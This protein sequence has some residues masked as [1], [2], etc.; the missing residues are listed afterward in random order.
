MLKNLYVATNAPRSGKSLISLGI[1]EILSRRVER[2]GFFRPVI[3]QTQAPD[4]DIEL[5]RQRYQL[6]VPYE[7]LY[8]MS[9][10]EV[11]SLISQGKSQEVLPRIFTRYKE[12]E[13][14][15][16]FILCEGSDLTGLATALEF[17]LN[18]QMANQIDAPVVVVANGYQKTRTENL[19]LAQLLKESFEEE[20]CQLLAIMLNRVPQD[21]IE[22]VQDDLRQK[23]THATP[24]YALPEEEI[25]SKPTI[26]R[27]AQALDAKHLCGTHGNLN[28]LVRDYKVAASDLSNFLP[29]IKD[30]SLVITPGDRADLIVGTL[31]AFQ[32]TSLPKVAGLILTG[33]LEPVPVVRRLIEGFEDTLPIYSVEADT[34]E[35]ATC[36]DDVVDTIAPDN[37][38]KVAAALGHFEKHVDLQKLESQ[39]EITRSGRITP[40]MFQ[41][42]LIERAQAEKKRVVLP[43]A[44]DERILR[45]AEILLRRNVVD[46]I[47]LG[48]ESTIRRQAEEIG[49]DLSGV[50]FVDPIAS[51]WLDNYAWTY[52]E[53]RGHKGITLEQARDIML[54]A[55]YFGTM[56]VYKDAADAM[57][58]GAIH[59]TSHTIRPALQFIKVHPS[60][61]IVSSVFFMCL[62]DQ[63]HVY[64]DCAVNPN[65][66][67]GELADIAIASAETAQSFGVEPRIAML[68]YSSGA[69]GK[70]E[71]VDKVRAATERVK[72]LRPD[73]MIEGPIQFDAAVDRD[74][75]RQKLPGSDVAGRAT[76]FIFPDL[77]T[78]NNTYK[79]VQR[80]ANAIA[81]GPVLQGLRKPV[82]DLSRGCSVAD[83]VN[84]VVITAIQAQTRGTAS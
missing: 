67:S 13:Q 4:N 44:T 82:N 62:A 65:P 52:Y 34:Y 26:G 27:V 78:G 56:M 20:D 66:D 23:W 80:S 71:D 19:N 69:S 3:R 40:V 41:Y 51:P 37:R 2:L 1:M 77:N 74:V 15:C 72:Q 49:V 54:D 55:S 39:F 58:S 6:Q 11:R 50:E 38:P 45:A 42:D 53:M 79:A 43:E 84:T 64:G 59:T 7:S 48:Q 35:T 33:G 61:N 70:G 57:V 32:S 31:A 22:D 18:A 68:S 75:A 16:D 29:R 76:V 60:R 63:V 25:L 46:I 24:V 8:G 21:L 5:M 47:L 83:I 14:H 17:D 30:G 36:V 28:R 81:M 12:L 73:L 10:D 9:M